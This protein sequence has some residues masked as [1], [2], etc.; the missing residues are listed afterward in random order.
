MPN[1]RNP[2]NE[3]ISPLLPTNN[4]YGIQQGEDSEEEETPNLGVQIKAEAPRVTT[5]KSLANK[6]KYT[7]NHSKKENNA[8]M[9]I[10]NT[11]HEK[12]E[13][14]DVTFNNDERFLHNSIRTSK[15][16][17]LSFFP[18]NLFHQLIKIANLYFLLISGMQMIPKITITE[19][20]PTTLPPLLFVM[21]VSM[22]KDFME[23]RKR[24]AADEQENSRRVLRLRS[25]QGG[26]RPLN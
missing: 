25:V 5:R 11:K 7:V 17:C 15:Y 10:F 2:T 4:N 3:Q 26:D 20:T 1:K 8:N 16:T 9:W 24:R 12:I 21:T 6:R 23:D 13:A 22:I 14:S 18:L 19:S